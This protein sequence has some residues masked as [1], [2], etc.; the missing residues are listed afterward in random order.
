MSLPH[1]KNDEVY[2]RMTVHLHFKVSKIPESCNGYEGVH[3]KT[4]EEG[5]IKQLVIELV[6][7]TYNS[8]YQKKNLPVFDDHITFLNIKQVAAHS[9]NRQAYDMTPIQVDDT[10]RPRG[11]VPNISSSQSTGNMRSERFARGSSVATGTSTL[12][13]RMKRRRSSSSRASSRRSH[14]SLRSG[15]TSSRRS[16]YD[17]NSLPGS[18]REYI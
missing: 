9:A 7:I 10:S 4:Y 5:K 15:I 6:S 12:S 14:T 17:N 8:T 2:F 3:I 18:M 13:S 11:M 16:N 1:N